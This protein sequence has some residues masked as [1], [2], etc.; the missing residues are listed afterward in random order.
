[1][2]ICITDSL[3]CTTE[4][5]H[6]KSTI[7]QLK[8][9]WVKQKYLFLLREVKVTQ[10]CLTLCNPKECP[11]HGILQARILEWVAFP[12]SRGSSQPRD[13]T[14]ISLI[15]GG[16][17]TSWATREAQV[18]SPSL[19][20]WIFLTQESN[21]GLLNDR[22]ILHQL[23]CFY[24]NALYIENKKYLFYKNIKL[25]IKKYMSY[26]QMHTFLYMYTPLSF[27]KSL[28]PISLLLIR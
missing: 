22:W 21:R 13:W 17:F 24:L 28:W 8:L 27:K 12:F 9:F 10:L 5:Q 11:V 18:G 4:T 19:L 23:S 15:T 3:R 25:N 2:D 26:T 14:Q 7:F 1:M 6:C 16:F 20:Q